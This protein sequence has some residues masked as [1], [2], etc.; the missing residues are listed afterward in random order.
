MKRSPRTRKAS[1]ARLWLGAGIGLVGA[2]LLVTT[3]AAAGSWAAT[4]PAPARPS[5]TTSPAFTV[6]P[7]TTDLVT[8]RAAATGSPSPRVI[9]QKSLS[10]LGPWATIA[11]ATGST[12]TTQASNGS[13][14]YLFRAVFTNIYG[15]AA[16]TAA[17]LVAR[18]NWMGDL[19]DDI[20]ST[21]LTELTIP[22]AHD[23]GTY[24]LDDTASDDGNASACWGVDDTVCASYMQAQDR[25]ITTQ[26]DEGIRYFDL[27][28]C[29]DGGL[30][31]ICHGFEGAFLVQVLAQVQAWVREHPHELVILDF[32]HNYK[33]DPDYEA[34]IIHGSLTYADGSSMA[35]DPGMAACP[36][37][38]DTTCAG[39][40]RTDQVGPDRALKGSVIVNFENDCPDGCGTQTLD[41]AFYGRHLSLWGRI[42]GSPHIGK[43]CSTGG[44]FTSCFG[45]TSDTP[46][47]LNSDSNTTKTREVFAEPNP[48][49]GGTFQHFFVQFLQ[50]TPDGA[51]I[52]DHSTG[53]LYDMAITSNPV[54]APGFL[55]C[56][57]WGVT[58][59][60]GQKR[61]E[62]LNIL[63]LNYY[64]L[65]DYQDSSGQPLQFDFVQ[66][67]LT[68][69]E[70]ARTAPVVSLTPAKAAAST[71]W[72]NAA[73]VGQGGT[74]NVG[75]SVH[76]YAYDTGIDAVSCTDTVPGLIVTGASPSP[77][78]LTQGSMTLGEGAHHVSC[79]A[80]DGADQGI[81]GHGNIG[82]GWGSTPM[83]ATYGVDT[84]PP[85][86]LCGGLT[87]LLL[88]AP[89]TSQNVWVADATSGPSS[90]TL[91]I[92]VSTSQVGAVSKRL[93]TTDNA[94]N[95]G[96]AT[97]TAEVEYNVVPTYSAV[98]VTVGTVKALTI[99]LRDHAGTSITKVRPVSAVS[100]IN[101]KT[102]QASTPVPAN[103]SSSPL[104]FF[105]TAKGFE[106]DLR[107]DNLTAGSYVLTFRAGRDPVLH[108]LPFLV[109]GTSPRPTP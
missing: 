31:V 15:S 106:F 28:V 102:K 29:S 51:Y 71:G 52:A 69:D 7:T 23:A 95:P 47:A 94:G 21:P 80:T 89:V 3:W 107:T 13:H 54:I 1:S 58:S 24:T 46:D 99:E 2:S 61:P 37:N 9:W 100:V 83:P 109:Q 101:A 45:N 26:L 19:G 57:E 81:H 66:A 108:S 59:C 65:T 33:V 74:V 36:D 60:F 75:L 87:P 38:V 67:V 79:S 32:N 5:V 34:D 43:Y 4:V 35:I 82:A 39:T 84:V 11:G 8:F 97:C 103:A 22:G 44:S 76:D 105:S 40:L 63:A 25:D 68:F 50:T 86:I 27:R 20:S 72:Y 16:T 55:G 90:S 85:V 91:S 78:Y 42:V 73:T 96:S 17:R 12:Y 30:Y 104:A 98:P 18:T 10:R 48:G 49:V 53:S 62:D 77:N 56:Y 93:T 70:N 14:G 88:H 64:N 6:V 92:P 41:Y